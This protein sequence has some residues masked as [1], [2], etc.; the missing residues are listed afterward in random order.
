MEDEVEKQEVTG[1]NGNAGSLREGADPASRRGDRRQRL[2]RTVTRLT[3]SAVVIGATTIALTACG[4][5]SN[6][7]AGSSSAAGASP[8]SSQSAS[9]GGASG[10][11]IKVM[12]IGPFNAPVAAVPQVGAGGQAAGDAINAAG[13]VNGHKVDVIL[14]DDQENP[15]KSAECAHQA[16]SDHVTAVVGYLLF[17][18]QVVPVLQAA[19]IPLVGTQLITPQEMTSPDSYPLQG[20]SALAYYALGRYVVSS[21]SKN[22]SILYDDQPAALFPTGFMKKGVVAAGGTVTSDVGFTEG[23]P[24]FAP[25]IAKALQGSKPQAIICGC[26]G[27][28]LQ[29]FVTAARQAGFTGVLGTSSIAVNNKNLS[30]IGA[31]ANGLIGIATEKLPTDGQTAFTAAMAKYESSAVVDELGFTTWNAVQGVAAALK[32]ASGTDAT[33]LTAALKSASALK[34]GTALPAI[35]LSKPGPF[36]GYPRIFNTAVWPYKVSDGTLK[37]IGTTPFLPFK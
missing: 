14:C 17:G 30:A 25:Y 18:P 12:V 15:N 22:V 29:P 31:Q 24:D 27:S 20:G 33:S 8:T 36:P 3:M 9:S 10:S 19:G 23:S 1:K 34:F 28:D 5:S 32:G 37:R 21:G 26:S 11:P 6:T 7:S 35:N 4:S 2:R 13:G 16:V